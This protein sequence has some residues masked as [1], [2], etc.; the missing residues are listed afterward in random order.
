MALFKIFNNIDSK[1]PVPGQDNQYTY[2]ELPSTYTKGYMYFDAQKKIFYIDLEGT[3]GTTGVRVALNAY[4]A[5]K[6]A[7][8]IDGNQID[9]TYLKIAD[10]DNYSS[11][12]TIK[13]WSMSAGS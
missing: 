9:T 12:V 2:N 7:K 4:G 6:A 3:G 8:D 11:Q 10:V 1:T 13:T 5:E